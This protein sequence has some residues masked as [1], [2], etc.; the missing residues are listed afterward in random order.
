MLNKN[1]SIPIKSDRCFEGEKISISADLL[2]FKK[3]GAKDRAKRGQK[4]I[5]FDRYVR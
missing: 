5:T 3:R 1:Q 2:D 4:P